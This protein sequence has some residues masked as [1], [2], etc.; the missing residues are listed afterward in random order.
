L[1]AVDVLAQE[2][3]C[4]DIFARNYNSRATLDD[5]S[6]CY[7]K[8]TINPDFTCG[9]PEEVCETSGLFFHNGKVWTHNDS[10]GK[11]ILY[12]LD[13]SGFDVVQR[14]TLSNAGNCD[15]EDVCS[16]GVRVFVGD[17]GNNRGNRN[18]LKIY[19]FFLSQIPDRG[20][21]VILVDTI[22]FTFADQPDYSQRYYHDFDC[23]AMFVTQK[24]LYLFSKG[25]KTEA[26]RLYRVPKEKGEFIVD[27]VSGFNSKGL[28][29]GADYDAKNNV[30]A[31]V[32]YKNKVW[33]PFLYL[34][35]DFDEENLSA[36]GQRINLP[37]FVT[38]QME[39]ICFYDDFRFL[40]LRKHLL[41]IK[42]ESLILIA[43]KCFIGIMKIQGMVIL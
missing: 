20:D 1:F 31:L 15:W 43:A 33:T 32:G 19:Y 3:G 10:G 22:C 16:D 2:E 38:T 6:C 28:I 13:T 26:T 14:I 25:W 8:Q 4:T 12:A 29:T 7:F 18:D 11:P 27:S 41:H 37:Q 24:Y 35:Y 9:L 34:I 39:G 5:G 21:A 42:R 40:F 36:H 23:E 30:L 17:F